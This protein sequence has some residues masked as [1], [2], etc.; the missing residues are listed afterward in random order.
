MTKLDASIVFSPENVVLRLDTND[1]RTSKQ[2]TQSDLSPESGRQRPISCL[3]YFRRMWT[4]CTR[5]RARC[6]VHCFGNVSGIGARAAVAW[7]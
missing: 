4:V 6:P 2:Q 5:G 1:L 3:F 7:R